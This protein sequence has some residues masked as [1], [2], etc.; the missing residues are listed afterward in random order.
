MTP[1]SATRLLL[2][3]AWLTAV[4]GGPAPAQTKAQS[5]PRAPAPAAAKPPASPCDVL[6]DDPEDPF[7]TAPGVEK[8]L[9]DTAK[10][11]PAC[12]AA[13][14][15]APEDGRVRYALARALD[16]AN[17]EDAAGDAYQRAAERGYP[18]AENMVGM[19]YLQQAHQPDVAAQWIRKSAD[20]GYLPAQMTLG[21]FYHQGIGV[22]KDVQQAVAWYRKASDAGYPLAQVT[23][24]AL[25]H[26]GDGVPQD[27]QQ[28]LALYRKAADA[29]Y[30]GGE[31]GIGDAYYHGWGVKQDAK[32]ALAWYQ[33]AADQGF[34]PALAALGVMYH[35]GE[36][37]LKADDAKAAENLKQ[38]AALGFAPAAPLLAALQQGSAK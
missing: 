19:L 3:A 28:A 8:R 11:I 36:G 35:N 24:G 37:G 23:L 34:P 22:P 32:Q 4:L 16:Q 26:K 15:A 9:I 27:D 6:A 14:D 18:I 5:K 38:A 21:A 17:D 2:A 7:R 20:H 25:Y 13:V 30:S 29:H 10:A 33:K 1:R 31:N 12:K